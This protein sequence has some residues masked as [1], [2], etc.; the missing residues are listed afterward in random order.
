MPFVGGSADS[1]RYLGYIFGGS[2]YS[3]NSS[4]VPRS[5][6]TVI[7]SNK[8]TSIGEDAFYYCS[9]LTSITIPDSVTSIGKDAFYGCSNLIKVNI[10]DIAKWCNIDFGSYKSNPLYYAHNLYL[11][12]TKIT[13]LVIPDGI[14]SIGDYAFSGC[15]SLTSITIPDSVTSI[16]YRTFEDCNSLTDVYYIGSKTEADNIDI[17]SGN[18]KFEDAKWYYCGTEVITPTE[19]G[20]YSIAPNA[21]KVFD[22]Q[23]K[24]LIYKDGWSLVKGK[25]YT[26]IFE[27]DNDSEFKYSLAKNIDD[28]F[29]DTNSGAWYNDAVT[30]AVGRGIISGYGNGNFGPAD[31]IQRQ[32]F[33]VIL[34]RFDG[35]DLSQYTGSS[36]FA[37]VQTGSYYAAA[38]NWGAEKGIVNGYQNGCFGVSDVITREQLVT[39]LCRYASSK[40]IDVSYSNTT[41]VEASRKYG[42]YSQVSD[43]SLDCVLWALENNVINGKNANTS[44]PT[45]APQGNAQRCEVAQIMYNIFQNNV[46]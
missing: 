18:Y 17:G 40:G 16:G 39:F 30:Y 8:C 5:L 42:D 11:N 15:S 44:S 10:T 22:E 37:D 9:S 19:T 34:A 31:S 32:D 38:V 33:L 29:P 43:W 3:D 35:V 14:T 41:A 24:G 4:Y 23:N 12:G 26:V 13:N 36:R 46:F 6:K 25:N 21:L 7:I 28:L 27:N 1:K 20:I 45:I 2:R